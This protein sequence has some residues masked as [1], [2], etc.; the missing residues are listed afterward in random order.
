MKVYD[1]NFKWKSFS[2][3]DT[4][5]CLVN[6]SLREQRTLFPVRMVTVE[7]PFD[8]NN[9]T[10]ID[11]EDIQL[12]LPSFGSRQGDPEFSKKYD[13]HP[14]VN[15]EGLRGDGKID[16]LDLYYL[17]SEMKQQD[18]LMKEIQRSWDSFE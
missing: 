17:V 12:F 5:H 2:A 14:T 16:F 18:A 3:T 4:N 10:W 9:D 8:F 7:N 13:I 6:Y 11:E 1:T 15:E